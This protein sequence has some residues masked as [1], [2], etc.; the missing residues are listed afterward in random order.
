[1]MIVMGL[2]MSIFPLYTFPS[3]LSSPLAGVASISCC[4]DPPSAANVG[5]GVINKR[6]IRLNITHPVICKGECFLI[7]FYPSIMGKSLIRI[8]QVE[9]RHQLKNNY[10]SQSLL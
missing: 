3:S 9:Y 6:I 8:Q 2:V 5:K 1:P 4:K 10:R 7:F